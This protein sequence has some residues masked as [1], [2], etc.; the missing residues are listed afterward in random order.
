[1]YM[2]QSLFYL[3]T[4]IHVSGVNITH[5]QER[6]QVY[7]QH[8]VFAIPFLLP[9]AIVKGL[10]L[11]RVCCGWPPTTHSNQFQLFHDSSRLQ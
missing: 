1:M 2:L 7:L 5:L 8:P 10:E 6:K 3:T 4:A 9:A 11:I